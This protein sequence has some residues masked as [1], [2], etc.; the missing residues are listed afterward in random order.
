MRRSSD[1]AT[2]PTGKMAR[3]T[4]GTAAPMIDDEPQGHNRPVRPADVQFDARAT[5]AGSYDHLPLSILSQ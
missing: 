1:S 2:T 4:M 5:L 3:P